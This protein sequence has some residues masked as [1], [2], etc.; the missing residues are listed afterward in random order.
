M[1]D[2]LQGWTVRERNR[3]TTIQR[4]LVQWL[5]SKY[6]LSYKK[7]KH[8]ILRQ[9]MMGIINKDDMLDLGAP[10]EEMTKRFLIRF[11][12]AVKRAK[13]AAGLL[14]FMHYMCIMAMI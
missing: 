1:Q 8:D 9:M 7:V 14:T 10:C 5:I 4:I 12:D 13:A 3:T 6:G 11:N 2:P